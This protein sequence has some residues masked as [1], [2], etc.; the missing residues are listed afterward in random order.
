[1]HMFI[2]KDMRGGIRSSQK[3]MQKPTIL[4]LRIMTQR[5]T[6]TAS[7]TMTRI[8]SVGGQG[9]SLLHTI[10]SNGKR[11]TMVNSILKR[12]RLYS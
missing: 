5:K 1:M 11:Q 8:I 10:V 7:C 2:V 4:I 9:V 12:Q 6:I 3:G